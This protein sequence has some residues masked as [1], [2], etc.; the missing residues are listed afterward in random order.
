[1]GAARAAR[2]AAASR[3]AG[4]SALNVGDIATTSSVVVVVVAVLLPDP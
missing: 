4:G 1:M 3:S 2:I